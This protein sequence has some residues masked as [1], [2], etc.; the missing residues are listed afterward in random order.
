MKLTS[1]LL[2]AAIMM[3]I[4]KGS[5]QINLTLTVRNERLEKVFDAV[6]KQTGYF[7]FFDEKILE[8]AGL[9]TINAVNM[10]LDKFLGEVLKDKSLRLSIRNKTI[11]I[12]S[13]AQSPTDLPEQSSSTPNNNPS[14]ELRGKV[15]NETGEPM[16]GATV[17]INAPKHTVECN[18]QGDFVL[19]NIPTGDRDVIVTVSFIGYETQSQVVRSDGRST[20]VFRMQLINNALDMVQIVAYG[21]TSRRFNVGSVATVSSKEIERQPV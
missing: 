4:G 9:V 12:S 18:S 17:S 16:S 21:T 7:F 5:A 19:K 1:L 13:T 11:T 15:I 8:T 3:S 20:L 14:A 2:L 6:E 10:P